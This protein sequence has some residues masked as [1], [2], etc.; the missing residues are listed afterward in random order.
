MSGAIVV[1]LGAEPLAQ[2]S[3]GADH[4]VGDHQH[5]VL[6]ADLAHA[7][8]VPLRWGE[9]TA[10]VLDRLEDHG[11]DGVGAL[12]LDPRGDRVGQG[13]RGQAGR[14]PVGVGVGDVAAAGVSGSNGSRRPVT[15]VAESAPRLVPW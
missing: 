13:V 10:G 5:V 14:Q 9:A 2:A 12:E 3:P 11:G 1:A 4:L 15:P 7:L 8:E 6:I